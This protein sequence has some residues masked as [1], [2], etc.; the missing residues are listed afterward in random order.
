MLPDLLLEP[1]VR[2]ALIE[3]LGPMGDATCRAVI[4]PGLTYAAQLNARAAG[5]ASGLRIAAMAFRLVDPALRIEPLRTDGQP[6]AAGD[7][8][9]RISG[10]ASSI[11][12]A[13]RVALNFAGRL[14]GIATL[15]AAFVAQT[16][17]HKARITCTRK[18]TPGLRAVEKEAV[19]H[20][21]GANHRYG[22]SDAI[23]IKDNHIAAAGGVRAVLAAAMAARSHMMRIE[24]EVDRLD[25]LAEVLA[26]GGA[27]VVLLDNMTTPQLA[28]AVALAAGRVVLEASG[29]MALPRIAEVAATGVDYISVGAL[30]HSAPVLDLGLDF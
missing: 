14:T 10:S 22:L 1:L 15:T 20:G 30:T 3:D 5:V 9:L 13:E 26:I 2:A 6:F 11:L 7:P 18:T 17:R 16:A 23:L 29:N 27:D 8:L 24:I 25:Q 21:G 12:M 4:P 28:E 19:R